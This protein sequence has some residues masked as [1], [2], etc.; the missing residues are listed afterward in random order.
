MMETVDDLLNAAASLVRGHDQLLDRVRAVVRPYGVEVLEL[1]SAGEGSWLL[2]VAF[3]GVAGAQE[4]GV[5]G[6][7][8]RV[9]LAPP[10]PPYI[11]P[12]RMSP[13]FVGDGASDLMAMIGAADSGVRLPPTGGGNEAGDWPLLSD[14]ERLTMLAGTIAGDAFLS[15][16][17]LGFGADA[18]RISSATAHAREQYRTEVARAGVPAPQADAYLDAFEAAAARARLQILDEG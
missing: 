2:R 13:P 14:D 11:S 9:P 18:D 1:H 7:A 5:P 17:H 16:Q 8:G 3:R 4:A 10:D 15:L 6:P 12:A